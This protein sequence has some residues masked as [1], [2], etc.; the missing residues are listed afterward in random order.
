M[1]EKK[2]PPKGL[3]RRSRL[4]GERSRKR[5]NAFRDLQSTVGALLQVTPA[6]DRKLVRQL[7]EL[8]RRMEG[9]V[10][11]PRKRKEEGV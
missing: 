10:P 1:A 4:L 8:Q 11:P 6:V 7:Q 9:R 3:V 2:S 5:E